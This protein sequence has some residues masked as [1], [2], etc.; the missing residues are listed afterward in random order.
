M[1]ILSLLSLGVADVSLQLLYIGAHEPILNFVFAKM[2]YKNCFFS[3]VFYFFAKDVLSSH[4]EISFALYGLSALVV[5]WIECGSPKAEIRVRFSSGV[6]KRERHRPLPFL[7]I[8]AWWILMLLLLYTMPII[9]LALFLLKSNA[10]ME[11]DAACC[12]GR[13][14]E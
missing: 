14:K 7:Y 13:A 2:M 4:S 6:Q 9:A 3:L 11:T 10:K 1:C 8:S 5:Q 12:N